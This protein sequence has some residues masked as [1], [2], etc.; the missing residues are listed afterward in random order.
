MEKLIL[1]EHFEYLRDIQEGVNEGA[2]NALEFYAE[3]KEFSG[4]IIKTIKAIEPEAQT[5]AALHGGKTFTAFGYEITKRAGY[6]TYNYEANA[7]F[8]ERSEDLKK[9]QNM[10]KEAS[11][12]QKSIIDED[13]GE[14]FQPCPI[15][16]GAKD[17]LV[18]KL[19]K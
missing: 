4:A 12:L 2:I 19:S 17:S 1:K 9:F 13:T 5:E 7:E 8:K 10:L 15:K 18:I 16:S 11:R 6:A 3:L 14:I